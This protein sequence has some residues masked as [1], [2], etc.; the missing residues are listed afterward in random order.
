MFP[1]RL[2]S[3]LR[4]RPTG[5]FVASFAAEVHGLFPPPS[6]AFLPLPRMQHRCFFF[7]R[8][9]LSFFVE[10]IF[11]FFSPLAGCF[12]DPS[13]EADGLLPSPCTFPPPSFPRQ[14]SSLCGGLPKIS[15]FFLPRVSSFTRQTGRRM[16]LARSQGPKPP[17]F[18]PLCSNGFFLPVPPVFCYLRRGWGLTLLD[19]RFFLN[20]GLAPSL[21]R[22]RSPLA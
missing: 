22:Q 20:I 17:F 12:T 15:F 11:S 14:T 8:N 3:T 19:S 10:E 5:T 4:L 18:I 1:L 21:V 7:F 2:R 16:P 9:L 6:A 13:V